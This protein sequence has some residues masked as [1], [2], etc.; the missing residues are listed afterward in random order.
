MQHVGYLQRWLPLG[1]RPEADAM[2][3]ER[4]ADRVRALRDGT[5]A[6]ATA[7]RDAAREA[8]ERHYFLRQD[9]TGTTATWWFEGPSMRAWL[10]TLANQ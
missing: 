5:P 9:L 3:R 2:D 6:W 7:H 4:G 10:A 1:A 8:L